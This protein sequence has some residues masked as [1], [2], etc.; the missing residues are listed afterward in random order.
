MDRA[1]QS[2]GR[3]LRKNQDLLWILLRKYPQ[4]VYSDRVKI[5]N[6]IPVFCFH[7]E[8]DEFL[9][10]VFRYLADNQYKSLTGDEYYERVVSGAEGNGKEVVL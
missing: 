6:E 2:L 7:W 1:G 5:V 9:E 8:S 4:F 3:T 10:R